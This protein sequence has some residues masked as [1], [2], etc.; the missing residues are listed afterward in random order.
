MKVVSVIN[1]KGGVGKS[2]LAA[3]LGAYAASAGRRVLMIDMDPQTHLTFSFMTPDVWRERYSDNRTFKNYFE[4]VINGDFVLPSLRRY[5]IPLNNWDMLKLGDEK[6]DLISS[7][8]GLVDLDTELASMIV[9]SNDNIKASTSLKAFSYLRNGL[10]ELQSEYDIAIIDCPPTFGVSVKNAL[11]A[12]DCYIIPAKL[13][14]LSMLGIDHLEENVEK[15]KQAC[16]EYI[17][18]LKNGSYERMNLSVLGI[19]PMMVNIT[20]GDTPITAQQEYMQAM[21]EHYYMFHYV[22]NNGS[23]FGGAPKDGVP[24]VLTRPRFNLTAKKIVKEL[25]DLGEEFLRKVEA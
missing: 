13:D 24:A 5:L 11:F 14:Y 2:T 7:H 17:D 15:L 20:K 21:K 8:L 18:T 6:F 3:N 10:A 16:D 22:R 9:V 25:K 4:A 1:Y 23:V 19:V 12:S